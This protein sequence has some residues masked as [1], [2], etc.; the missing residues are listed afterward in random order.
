MAVFVLI[1]GAG[2]NA[3][4]WDRLV[5]ELERRDHEAIAVDIEEDDPALGLPEYADIVSDAIGERRN[6][7]L[8]AQSLGGFTAPVVAARRPI[9]L[10]VLVNAMIP[11]PGE[12]PGNWW[13][14]TGATEARQA[15]D[16]AAGRIGFDVET[17]F[18][19][20]LPAEVKAVLYADKPREP[21]D[22]PFRQPC[23]V[24]QW[25]DV[26]TRVV[27]GRDDRFF[28]VEFQVRVARDRLGVDADLIRGGHLVALANPDGLAAR[29]VAYVDAV[30]PVGLGVRIGRRR[31]RI[32]T[33]TGSDAPPIS[34][35]E[36]HDRPPASD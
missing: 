22:T 32:R 23:D 15:A 31:D 34:L 28:P 6:V 10:L 24:A 11:V 13:G 14:N 7:V 2:G 9:D 27:V 36:C 20:D 30:R 3:A 16:A 1:P 33:Q 18:V 19:H 35:P 29:L 17:H 26:P 5:P 8:V 12:T 25:P 4:Y 21:A